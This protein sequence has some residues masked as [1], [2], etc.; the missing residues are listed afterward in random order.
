MVASSLDVLFMKL[1]FIR[2]PITIVVNWHNHP[3]PQMLEFDLSTR[4]K[5]RVL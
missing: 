2:G 3:F 4:S 5:T 1:I